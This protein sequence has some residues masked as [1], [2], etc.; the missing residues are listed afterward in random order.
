MYGRNS[1][2]KK[3]VGISEIMS[4]PGFQL[5][6]KVYINVYKLCHSLGLTKGKILQDI[7]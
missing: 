7:S 6:A 1:R 2:Y 3:R 4:V 5:R